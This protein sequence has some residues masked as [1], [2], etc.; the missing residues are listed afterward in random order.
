MTREE[1]R[2]AVEQAVLA[3]L[4]LTA[5]KLGADISGLD[6][7]EAKALLKELKEQKQAA[8]EAKQGLQ[9]PTN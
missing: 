4:Q 6:K 1:A 9:D 2:A 7:S 5:D 3:K 8:K